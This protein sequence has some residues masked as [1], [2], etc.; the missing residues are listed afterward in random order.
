MYLSLARVPS[1]S[2]PADWPSRSDASGLEAEAL[3]NPDPR[4]IFIKTELAPLEEIVTCV[5]WCVCKKL[6]CT[7][8]VGFVQCNQS[9]YEMS[10]TR[11]VDSCMLI[12]RFLDVRGAVDLKEQI[13]GQP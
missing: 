2:N 7:V 3:P 13:Q 8:E 1:A 10:Q 11:Y 5:K 9:L 4:R 6:A 12:F